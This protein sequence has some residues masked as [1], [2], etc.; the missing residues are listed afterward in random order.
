MSNHEAIGDGIL[1][2]ITKEEPVAAAFVGTATVGAV[3]DFSVTHGWVTST[4]A[5]S[6]TQVATTAATFVVVSALGFVVRKFVTPV[7]K[8]ANKIDPPTVPPAAP[9]V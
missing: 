6:L 8:L 4:Q 2:W 3:L 9:T 1:A 5:S 7:A